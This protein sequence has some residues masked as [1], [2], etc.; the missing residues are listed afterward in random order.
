MVFFLLG[1][2][3]LEQGGFWVGCLV[4]LFFYIGNAWC[5]PFR[6]YPPGQLYRT[7]VVPRSMVVK[8]QIYKDTL[9]NLIG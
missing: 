5:C 3:M 8:N 1:S 6:V 9:F 2:I 4:N 7:R